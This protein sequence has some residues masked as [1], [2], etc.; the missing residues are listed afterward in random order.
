MIDVTS[1]GLVLAFLAGP[2]RAGALAARGAEALGDNPRWLLPLARRVLGRFPEPP[3]EGAAPLA[4]MLRADEA[5]R[6]AAN[7]WSRTRIRRWFTPETEMVAV[8]GPP[9][10]FAVP[11]LPTLGDLAAALGLTPPELDWFADGRRLNEATAAPALAHYRYAWVAKAGG[12]FRLLE[13]PKPRLREIQRWILRNVLAAIPASSRAHGFVRTR[14]VR[15]FARPHAGRDVVVRLDLEDFFASVSRA[16]VEALFRRVGYPHP[17]A[18]ALANL[19]TLGTPRHVLDAHPRQGQE[20]PRRFLA[21]ARLRVRHLPQGAPTSPALSNLVAWRLDVRLAALARGFDAVMTRYADDLAFS[22]GETFTRALRFFLPRAGAIVLEEGFHLNHRKTR[23][24]PRD[25]RQLL[26]GL[27]VNDRPNVPRRERDRLRAILF[28]VGRFGL[29]NQN[30]DGHPSFRRHL[31][32]R[33]AWVNAVHGGP[34]PRLPGL[35]DAA[36]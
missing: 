28:N 34:S 18:A 12:G 20:L 23:V 27:V 1:R 15:S 6:K 21:N 4:A 24:M 2:W 7:D 25:E 19:C 35:P 16:R 30:R 17:V 8:D 3:P 36:G 13:A 10:D 31:E 11:P 32:G 14:D 5:F 33:I 29:D 9:A 22:G 26:C